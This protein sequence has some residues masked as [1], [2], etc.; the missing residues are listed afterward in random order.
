MNWTTEFYL[1]AKGNSPVEDL[2][3]EQDAKTKAKLLRIIDL[4]EEFGLQIPNT[5]VEKLNDVWELKERI[6]TERYRILYFA[7]T[8]KKFILLH[9]FIKKTQKTPKDEILIAEH[10]RTD[11]IKRSTK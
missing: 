11:Y 9:A 10:R 1:D 3:S 8:G 4:L 6:G 5:W 7:H 2:I